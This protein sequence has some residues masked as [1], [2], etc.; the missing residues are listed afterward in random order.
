MQL[1]LI[2]FIY[3]VA[4]IAGSLVIPRLEAR[5]F[6]HDLDFSI[7]AAQAYLSAVASG[8]MALTGIVFSIAFVLCSSTRSFTRLDSWFGLHAIV[9]CSTHWACSLQ[10][11]CIALEPLPGSTEEETGLYRWSPVFLWFLYH[12]YSD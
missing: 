11:S 2:P 8:M 12:L 10:P 3:A 7:S 5:Y 1:W 4:S 6:A 9:S